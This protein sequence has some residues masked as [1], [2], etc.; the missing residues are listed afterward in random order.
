VPP[1]LE[2]V[3]RRALAKNPADRYADGAALAEALREAGRPG[4]VAAPPPPAETTQVLPAAVPAAAA[5]A[6]ATP[7]ADEPAP[8]SVT[9][10]RTGNRWP[11]Y[12]AG[13]LALVVVV[14]LLVAHP[15]TD[16]TAADDGTTDDRVQVKASQ[17]I[18]E[19]V[20]KV[21]A[22]LAEKGLE[23]ETDEV[24]NDGNREAGTVADLS[25][26]GRVE[27]GTT[28]TLQVWGEPTS[29]EGDEED[30]GDEGKPKPEKTKAPKP[31]K[32]DK[33]EEPGPDA[34]DTPTVPD[35]TEGTGPGDTGG[36]DPGA[37]EGPDADAGADAGADTGG[38]AQQ[39]E[40]ST[41]PKGD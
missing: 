1:A 30:Q 22:A 4:A 31:E 26:T 37:A 14:A 28:I 27:P 35:P 16:D 24:T 19:P 11:L 33:T 15:W 32:P 2:A 29:D 36:T 12:A 41:G 40:P 21:E 18:G 8:H 25:P 6:A 10:T 34:T 5:A 20:E 9:T 23:T 3:V 7:R 39:G 13:L 38:R 17:Y